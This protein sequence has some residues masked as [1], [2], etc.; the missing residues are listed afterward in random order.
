MKKAAAV[1]LALAAFLPL[2]FAAE[3]DYAPVPR[4]YNSTGDVAYNGSSPSYNTSNLTAGEVM[5]LSNGSSW[6]P[7]INKTQI[8]EAVSNM[9]GNMTG[10]L[11]G[12]PPVDDAAKFLIEASPYLLLLLGI[13]LFVLSGFMKLLAI[14]IIVIALIRILWGFL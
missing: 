12:V 11:T 1:L 5:N 9:T 8:E 4:Q 2:A 7:N 3:I 14:V 6:L 13:V 10:N